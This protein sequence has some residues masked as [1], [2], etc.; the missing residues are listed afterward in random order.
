MSN[1]THDGIREVKRR[2][3]SGLNARFDNM[4]Q[5]MNAVYSSP[6]NF[7]RH[8]THTSRS[9]DAS[10]LSSAVISAYSHL[11]ESRL[12]ENFT[13]I[14]IKSSEINVERDKLALSGGSSLEVPKRTSPSAVC[15]PLPDWLCSTFSTLAEKH[16]LRLLL[17]KQTPSPPNHAIM[18][19]PATGQN[20]PHGSENEATFAFSPHQFTRID[21]QLTKPNDP[22]C[23]GSRTPMFLDALRPTISDENPEGYQVHDD[24]Q[25]APLA[26]DEL[27]FSTPGPSYLS[28]HKFEYRSL[29]STSQMNSQ[30][31][32]RPPG[33]EDLGFVPFATPGPASTVGSPSAMTPY[34]HILPPKFDSFAS[35]GNIEIGLSRDRTSLPFPSLP[36]DAKSHTRRVSGSSI[37]P[38]ACLPP[39]NAVPSDRDPVSSSDD[40]LD[41]AYYEDPFADESGSD[42]STDNNDFKTDIMDIFATPGPG[43]CAPRPIYFKSPT[44]DPSESDPVES[45]YEIDV[46]A[47]DFKWMPFT[48]KSTRVDNAHTSKPSFP[49]HHDVLGLEPPNADVPLFEP[50]L[51]PNG[52]PSPNPFRFA[53]L[54]E[55][56]ASASDETPPQEIR[57][58]VHNIT[59]R[60][61]PQAFAPAPGIYISPLRGDT[62][63]PVRTGSFL[64][65]PG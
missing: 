51:T 65:R 17:P 24:Q 58:D 60:G 56:I 18:T 50:P 37:A 54:T 20:S 22:N 30:D 11:H 28:V 41:G 34:P 26:F 1:A 27:P 45:G 55:P 21:G 32:I 36:T 13:L 12:G 39:H 14:K 35:T 64:P 5:T 16:P 38:D 2:K 48:G 59:S 61:A 46:D 6:R 19:A 15:K 42:L 33:L 53:P 25:S 52:I 47:I 3:T 10:D 7:G 63:E 40:I 31:S 23:I 62:K 9:S 29:H 43:F 44:E 57:D 8:R 4:V 49:A